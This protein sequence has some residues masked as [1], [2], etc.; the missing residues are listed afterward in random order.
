[1]V[2]VKP[3]TVI[4]WH[5]KGYRAYWW[6]KSRAGRVGRPRIPRKHIDFISRISQEHPEWGEDRISEE[7]S[8]K[9]GVSHSGSTVRRYMVSRRKGPRG[10]QT[11]RTFIKNHA[12]QV[13]SCDFVTQYTALFS[14]V[15]VL[16]I[17]EIGSRRVTQVGVTTSP[18]LEWVKQQMRDATPYDA[19]PRFLVHDNDGIFGQFK[20]KVTVEK[21][22]KK[23]SYRCA[24]DLWL[25]EV[26]GIE[27]LPIPYGAPNAN[28]HIERFARTLRVEALN[29]F[30]FLSEED[31][32]RVVMEFIRYYNGARPSQ[33]I[34]AIPDPYPELREPP[35]TDGELVGLPVLG[36]LHHDYRLTA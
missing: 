6:A 26:I 9:F 14:T 2:I 8:A 13:W 27:G 33:A 19:T 36:G 7:L 10:D 29:H 32:R 24:L 11:W 1:M 4:A 3:A 18:T 31:V 22:G 28:P 5:R 35:P 30:I 23:R 20:R 34:H 16:V 15:Y 25:R 12:K 21:N 17:M